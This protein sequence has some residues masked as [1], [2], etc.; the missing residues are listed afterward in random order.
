MYSLEGKIIFIDVRNNIKGNEI[1][2]KRTRE[3]DKKK[4]EREREFK[5]RRES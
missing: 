2:K 4:R 3:R 5:Y 1:G